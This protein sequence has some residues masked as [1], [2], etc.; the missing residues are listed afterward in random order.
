MTERPKVLVI[1]L[2]GA[3]WSVLGPWMDDGTLPNLRAIRDRGVHGELVSTFPPLTPP[4]WATFLTGKNPAKHGV[5]HFAQVHDDVTDLSAGT[6][7]IVDSRDIRSATLWDIVS[8]HERELVTINVPMSYP[9]RPV[10]GVMVT[11][12]LTPADA[13]VFTYPP[14][15]SELLP[16]Y[17]IDLERFIGD[18]PFARDE[19]GAKKKRTVEPSLELLDEFM[20]MEQSRA[21]VSLELARTE[22]W[23]VFTVVFTGPDRLGHYLWTYHHLDEDADDDARRLHAGIRQ[24]Y[25]II[26]DAVGQLVEVAGDTSHVVV[27]SD[28]GMGATH[29]HNVHWNSWL[30]GKGLL[31]PDSAAASAPDALLLRLRLPRDRIGRIVRR[32]PGL[33]SSAVI[34]RARTAPAMRPDVAASEAYYVR[35]F[36]PLGGIRVTATG[37]RRDEIIDGLLGA[38]PDVIDPEN[39]RRVVR[40]AFRRETY[41]EGPYAERMPDI[42]LLMDPDY[43][44]S[45]RISHYSSIV[46]PRTSIGDSGAHELEGV[47]MLAG[48]EIATDVPL[49]DANIADVAP[50]ILHLL[51]L[52]VPD[53]MDGSVLSRAMTEASRADRPVQSSGAFE[54]WPSEAEAEIAEA[55]SFDSDDDRVRDRLRDLGYVE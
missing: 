53:D 42:L 10:N 44:S 5:F 54:R 17:R 14:E 30:L 26:D 16:D 18:K 43:G 20:E 9:P 52:P 49:E 37:T 3:T 1:G 8:H 35:L 19:E 50:T 39:G 13:K 36:D 12:L 38:L 22:P 27:L 32:I 41:F 31:R 7:D 55:E 40:R 15:L 51:G 21:T 45:D 34:E 11:C 29:R 23:D 46:T 48:P 47:V 6:P 24:V 33:R 25:R 28:H 2:D 4:A